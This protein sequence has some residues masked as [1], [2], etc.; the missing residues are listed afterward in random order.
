MLTC[1]TLH[2]EIWVFAQFGSGRLPS[3]SGSHIMAHQRRPSFYQQ[4]MHLQLS[5]DAMILMTESMPT[6]AIV[7]NPGP[8]GRY[9]EALI[10]DRRMM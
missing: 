10:M 3:A 9:E 8:T 5:K 7:S 6:G 2:G 4:H 1:D